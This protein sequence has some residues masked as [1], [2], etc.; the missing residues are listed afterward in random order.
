M[1]EKKKLKALNNENSTQTQIVIADATVGT[2]EERNTLSPENVK[3]MDLSL[4]R[5][6]KRLLLTKTKLLVQAETH[7]LML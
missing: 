4:G 6:Q 2:F 3:S 5:L 1:S 7:T